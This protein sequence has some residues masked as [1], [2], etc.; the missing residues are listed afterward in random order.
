MAIVQNLA[1]IIGCRFQIVDT[2]CRDVIHVASVNKNDV[3]VENRHKGPSI[4][5]VETMFDWLPQTIWSNC[6]HCVETLLP[7]MCT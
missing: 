4:L 6:G 3:I 1:I 2:S 5:H 7:V